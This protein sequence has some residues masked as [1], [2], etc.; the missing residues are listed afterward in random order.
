MA[1]LNQ[2]LPSPILAVPGSVVVKQAAVHYLQKH[3]STVTEAQMRDCTLSTMRPFTDQFET[4]I[5][6]NDPKDSTSE[7]APFRIIQLMK[8]T[9][10]LF[11]KLADPSATLVEKTTRD[12]LLSDELA[13]MQRAFGKENL[14]SQFV[15]CFGRLLNFQRRFGGQE[16]IDGLNKTL[17][18]INELK[19]LVD[20]MILRLD[21]IKTENSRTA[22]YRLYNMNLTLMEEV[23]KLL[24]QVGDKKRFA[25][26]VDWLGYR[27]YECEMYGFEY[28]KKNAE[29]E[30]W[31]C[32]K[33]EENLPFACLCCGSLEPN[34]GD[35][36][37]CSGCA[38]ARYCSKDCQK[39]H[40]KDHKK[41]CKRVSKLKSH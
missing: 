5:Q 6:Y 13:K 22:S 23:S 39:D 2:N 3:Q 21:E 25:E 24:F 7:M 36:K 16:L 28:D 34:R 18:F 31:R 32:Y 12:F 4:M 9:I 19:D 17:V 40:W 33:K 27:G 11:A 30:L 37:I 41:H 15:D 29:I 35:H 26:V 38:N 10:D 14:I 8:Q 1:T 20:S